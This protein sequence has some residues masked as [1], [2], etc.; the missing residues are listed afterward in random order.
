MTKCLKRQLHKGRVYPTPQQGKCC[1]RGRRHPQSGS[2]ELNAGIE[3]APPSFFFKY[4]KPVPAGQCSACCLLPWA[5]VTADCVHWGL[6]PRK[7][8]PRWMRRAGSLLVA[9][10]GKLFPH[11]FPSLLWLAGSCLQGFSE[12]LS[13]STRYP[14]SVLMSPTMTLFCPQPSWERL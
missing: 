4:T 6:T 1:R 8:S 7:R 12:F 3:L 2:R 11:N 5:P 13:Y 14:F 10:W 9:L